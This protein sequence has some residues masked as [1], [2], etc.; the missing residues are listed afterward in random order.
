MIK[1]TMMSTGDRGGDTGTR[2]IS[3][4]SFIKSTVAGAAALSL[5]PRLLRAQQRTR[6]GIVDEPSDVVLVHDS[7]ASQGA[8]INTSVTRIMIDEGIKAL[9]GENTVGEAWM[10]LLPDISPEHV[11]GIKVNA[12]SSQLP[13]HPDVVFPLVDS[14]QQMM[15]GGEPF[16]ENNIIIWD[17]TNW[18]LTNCGYT[19]NTGT[20]GVRCFGTQSSGVGYGSTT[21]YVH[22]VAQHFSRILEEYI[23]HNINVG[24]LKNHGTAGVALSLKNHYG[25]ASNLNYTMHNNHCD[26]YIPALNA[27][28]RDEFEGRDR[29]KIIDAVFGAHYGGPG[30]PPTFVENGLVMSVDPVAVDTVAMGILEDHGCPTMGQAHYVATAADPPYSLGNND[31]ELIN[32]IEI[33]EPSSGVGPSEGRTVPAVAELHPN[34]PNPFN[35]R[36]TIPFRLDRPAEIRLE[37]FSVSGQRVKVLEA[38]Q[39]GVGLYR[40]VWDG[41]NQA[42]DAVGS[43]MYFIRLS[44]PNILQTRAITLQK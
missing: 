26:P 2:S 41:T 4:R 18:E 16:P 21:Y 17:R 37:I 15:F 33:E 19:I 14:L 1:E 31:P 9:T 27:V 6:W 23:H 35:P 11:I 25:S 8:T 22:G 10:S 5:A 12:I 30:G 3:R 44:G 28:I 24:V 7:H 32:L 40:V 42:G 20:T 34:Y 29:V 39:K 13:S 38:G 36:T 43:G